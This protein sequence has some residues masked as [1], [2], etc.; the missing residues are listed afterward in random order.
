MYSEYEFEQGG[1]QVSSL[2]TS[3]YSLSPINLSHPPF[4]HGG[5]VFVLQNLIQ[6]HTDEQCFGK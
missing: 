2:E 5:R 3:F 1:L 6:T 4:T